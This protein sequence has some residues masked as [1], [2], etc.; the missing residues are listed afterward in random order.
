MLMRTLLVLLCVAWGI[1][2]G[3]AQSKPDPV[4]NLDTLVVERPQAPAVRHP[5]EDINRLLRAELSILETVQDLDM[6]VAR[7]TTELEVLERQ[8][9]VIATDVE[10]MSERFEGLT[11]RLETARTMVKR[12]LRAVTQLK[13]TEPYQILFASNSYANFLRRTRAVETL[14]DGDKERIQAFRKELKT[15]DEARVDLKRRRGNLARTGEK[16]THLIQQLN[17]DREEKK[18][19]LEAVQSRQ[20]FHNKVDIELRAIDSELKQRVQALRDDTKRLFR[21][22]DRQGALF[23][24]IWK[25]DVI[26]RFGVRIHPRFGT[27]TVRR[28]LHILPTGWDG[29][30]D[31]SV[32]SIYYGYVVF[33]GWL[34]GL[35]KTVIVD[36]TQGYMSLYAHLRD[37]N[38]KE[39][40][41]I[42]TRA[43]LGT[44]GETSSLSGPML[45]FE[46][47]KNGRA[48][49]PTAWFRD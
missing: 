26:G 34:E 14:L 3:H 45:Y 48:I 13:R 22:E 36:H 21:F 30:Q 1:P 23:K 15:W 17:W 12:R 29:K 41:T 2:L 28:G 33:T 31:V 19:L 20:A 11:E 27:R 10:R 49:D 18:V 39:G 6:D 40:D 9:A 47:R 25:G 8:Q 32:R 16:I 4:M 42:N 35:G 37:V 43:I 5:A 46:L 7:R 24:P 44:M 38:V